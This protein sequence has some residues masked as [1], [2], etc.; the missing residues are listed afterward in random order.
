LKKDPDLILLAS[1]EEMAV[2]VPGKGRA[3]ILI[4]AATLIF[5][6]MFPDLTGPIMISG[7][8]AMMLTGIITNEEA[9]SSIGWRSV[10]LV[11][12]MVPMGI[13]LIKTGASGL[14]ADGVIYAF[15]DFGKYFILAGLFLSTVVL[16]QAVNGTVA[17][18]IAGPIAIS[19]AAR[20]G[21]DARSLV[22]VVALGSSMAFITPLSHAVNIMVM[23]PGG[24]K[25]NDF[26]RVGLP[27]TILLFA[28]VMI[29]LP[30]FWPLG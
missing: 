26:M 3:A 6:T 2:T 11:G 29:F 8:L 13:A 30:I 27:L 4:F 19:I 7:A 1:D 14:F 22:M 20:A 15:G 21:L 24:Y 28:V 10:F 5:A 23:S 9:Y 25:F 16:T 17:A 18:T 12:G